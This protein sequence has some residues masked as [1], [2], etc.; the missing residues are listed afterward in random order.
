MAKILIV[1]DNAH[2]A[3]LLSMWLRKNRHE[4]EV[5][6]NG[7][8]AQARLQTADGGQDGPGIDILISDVNM[9]EM[10]GIELIRWVRQE[11][12]LDIPILVLSSRCDQAD[13]AGELGNQGVRIF[14]KPFSPSRLVAEI[15]NILTRRTCGEDATRC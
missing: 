10:T 8:D 13:M 11:R 12:K 9:P 4:V 1:E 14:A 6:S 3:S 2:Q 7:A 5:A 15:E